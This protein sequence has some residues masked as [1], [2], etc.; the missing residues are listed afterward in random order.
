MTLNI[1]TQVDYRKDIDGLR[2]IAV[3]SVIGFHAFPGYFRGGFVGVDVFFG[4]SGYLITS[5]IIKN[6]QANNFSLL[7]FYSKRI[8][9]IF[10]ALIL[11][12]TFFRNR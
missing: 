3:M 12:R 11:V 10:P 5:I 8:L 6:I 1:E 7:N 9:R 4:I 2:A